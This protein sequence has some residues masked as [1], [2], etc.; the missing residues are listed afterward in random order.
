[1]DVELLGI[2]LWVLGLACL[3]PAAVFAVVA[4]RGSRGV[5]RWGH[6]ACW[7][8]LAAACAVRVLGGPAAAPAAQVLAWAGLAA[9]LLFLRA[10][11]GRRAQRANQPPSTGSS[12]PWT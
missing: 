12:A 6:P 9:Y 5:L 10:L 2:P 7:V 8:L 3:L 1:V 11:R 4:P